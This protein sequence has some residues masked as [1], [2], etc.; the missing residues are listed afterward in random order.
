MDTYRYKPKTIARVA[1]IALILICF[2]PRCR[3]NKIK[4]Q[5][6]P[7]APVMVDTVIA[8]DVPVEIREIGMVEAY[9]TVAVT[10]RIGGQLL[11]M[12]FKEGSEVKKGDLL[13]KIDSGPFEAA[14][15]QAQA[16]LE[17]DEVSLT[18]ANSDVHRYEG[19]AQKDYVTKQDYDAVVSTAAEIKAAVA[20]DKAIVENAR[21]NLEYCSIRAPLSGRTGTV[22]I[23]Q[24]TIVV[25]NNPTPLVT[26]D[27]IVP[28]KVRFSVSEQM[29]PQVRRAAQN[30]QPIVR[31]FLS[32][33]TTR[34]FEGKLTFID[35]AVDATTGTILLKAT[36]ANTD[37]ALW[38]G[39]YV[40]VDLV[41]FKQHNAIVVPEAAL[42]TSQQGDFVYAIVSGDSAQMR[43]V[44]TGAQYKGWVVIEKGVTAGEKVVIDGQFGLAPGAKVTFKSALSPERHEVGAKR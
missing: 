11:Q 26:I 13:F 19:L 41:L 44:T 33:D 36:F 35:N 32:S 40:Q 14:L 29:L 10:A 3:A 5:I 38:P 4:G 27:Q 16:N 34:I 24:G 21:L 43:P 8:M 1:I 42:Q 28:I 17:R 22:L 18:K 37:Q 31:V 15:A 6:T 9:N 7:R 23:K 2:F 30:A 20:A 25:A 12:K 39:Q